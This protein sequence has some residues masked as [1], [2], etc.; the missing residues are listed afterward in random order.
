MALTK[1]T[2]GGLDGTFPDDSIVNADVNSSAAIAL[3]KLASTPATLTGTTNNQ[4]VSVTAANAITGESKLLFD[5]AKLTIGDGSTEDTAIIFDGNEQD[6]H[7]ALDDSNNYFDIGR[8]ATIGGGMGIQIHPTDDMLFYA[9]TQTGKCMIKLQSKGTPATV[10]L[11]DDAST[12]FS[13]VNVASLFMFQ[14]NSSYASAIFWVNY[15]SSTVVKIADPQG[16]YDVADTDGK[17]CVTHTLN[18]DDVTIKNR[19][20]ST[21]TVSCYVIA[22]GG[23]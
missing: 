2:S 4:V 18:S 11:A 15:A 19:L 12:T 1:V 14:S 13:S 10:S 3:S 9:G 7:I 20:G 16:V 5:P 6:Y 22:T 21:K 17:L 8:G 23:H